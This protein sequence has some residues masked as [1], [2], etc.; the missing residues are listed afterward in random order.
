LEAQR[1]SVLEGAHLLLYDGV[2]GL[3][4]RMIQLVLARD[5]RG[6]FHFASLQSEAARAALTPFGR[7]PAD[8]AT[9]Y[10]LVNY[11]GAA[12]ILLTRSR[13]VLFVLTALGWPWKAAALLS[14]VPPSILDRGYDVIA[15][16]RYRV[17]GRHEHCVLPPQDY[18]RR[19][20]DARANGRPD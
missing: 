18:Q 8:M 10:V 4:N 17:F 7:T 13:A 2:C 6:L 11:R 12:P 3:C 1:S 14:V 15:R 16:H 20:L 19:F 9:L 5:R